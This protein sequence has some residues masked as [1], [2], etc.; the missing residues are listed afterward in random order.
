MSTQKPNQPGAPA[1]KHVTFTPA[2]EANQG[3]SGSAENADNTASSAYNE[4]SRSNSQTSGASS[5]GRSNSSSQSG[6]QNSWLDQQQWL[7]NIDLKQVKDLGTKA[8][9]QVN[10]LSPTQKVV[11]GA[12]LVSGLSW[13][14]LRSK[15]SSSKGETYRSYRGSADSSDKSSKWN[16]AD[17][18]SSDKWNSSS[19]SVYRGTTSRTYG[20]D[21]YATDL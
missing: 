7:K 11:G 12:L 2:N 9:D 10:R 18:K 16:S 19:E 4:A 6:Q 15:S 17:K 5:Q 13:L 14:A 3:A 20:E 21:D 1:H 8:I